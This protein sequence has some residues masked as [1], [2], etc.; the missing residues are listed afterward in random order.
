MSLGFP[1]DIKELVRSRT[2]IVELIGD[3]VSL[4]PLRGGTDYVGLC[5]FHEDHNPSFHVYPQQQ[6]YRCWVCAE[7]GDCFSFLQKVE[8]LSFPDAL[9]ELAL[10]ADVEIPKFTGDIKAAKRK[11]SLYEVAAW[12]EEE[13]HRFLLNGKDAEVAREYLADRDYHE[14]TIIKYRLGYHPNEWEWLI[15]RARGKYDCQQLAAAKLISERRGGGG[16]YDYF[17]DRVLFPIRDDRGRPVAFGGRVIPGRE[18]PNSGK[19]FNSV[20]SELFSKSRI[21][22]AFDTAKEAIRKSKSVVV[23]EGYTDCIACHEAGVT[24]TVATL[25]TALT[26]NHVSILKRFAER[27]VLLYD[28]DQ[29]GR[30]SAERVMSR[31]A[32]TE[33]DLRILTLPE[34]Q[35]PEEFIGLNGPEEMQAR[36]SSAVEAWEYKYNALQMRYDMSSIDGRQRVL[37]GMLEILAPAPSLSGTMRESVI[38]GKLSWDTKVD[39]A[40]IRKRLDTMR[41]DSARKNAFQKNNANSSSAMH[42]ENNFPPPDFV[43]HTIPP[44]QADA[45]ENEIFS[46]GGNRY[47]KEEHDL[48]EI[49]FAT[50]ECVESIRQQI[51]PDDFYDPQ[52]KHLLQL[53]FDLAEQGV[54]PSYGSVTTALEDLSFKKLALE[55]ETSTVEKEIQKKIKNSS[56]PS[57]DSLPDFIATV[58]NNLKWRRAKK[59]HELS[60]QQIAL[61]PGSELDS[62]IREKLRQ[63]QEFHNQR[64]KRHKSSLDE[65]RDEKD[66]NL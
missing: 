8:N 49:I 46:T 45:R 10:R 30:D 63:I 20:E 38:I 56:S 44:D 21:L 43:E 15:E 28:G 31:F 13:F 18:Q 33:L 9:R 11:A 32:A 41:K 5:P 19:Y 65:T 55:I 16:F 23:V 47:R 54:P 25:G 64:Q 35:D 51:G 6:S 22:Y 61:S 66:S 40:S 58:V 2:S 26:E 52:L 3:K 57:P 42:F 60:K 39:E 37:D 1:N 7:G 24:N 48:L 17:V 53:C 14:E 59:S 62:D 12:A 36:I 29:A 34:N 27:V 4:T 50:P